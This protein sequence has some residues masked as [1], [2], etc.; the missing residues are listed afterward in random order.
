LE[1]VGAGAERVNTAPPRVG[2]SNNAVVLIC[3]RC[4]HYEQRTTTRYAN[5]QLAAPTQL[6]KN[7]TEGLYMTWEL[8]LPARLRLM[9]VSGKYTGFVLN[10]LLSPSDF[11]PERDG[12]F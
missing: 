1:R 9:Q 2:C 6:V 3:T 10:S 7:A 4:T 5:L 12:R 11:F 8:E